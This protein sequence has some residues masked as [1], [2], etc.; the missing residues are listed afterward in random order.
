MMIRTVIVMTNNYDKYSKSQGNAF[1]NNRGQ[2]LWCSN[3]NIGNNDTKISYMTLKCN[4]VNNPVMPYS[5]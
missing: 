4:N 3:A 5:N 2:W 1:D